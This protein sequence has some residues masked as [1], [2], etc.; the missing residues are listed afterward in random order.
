MIPFR[1]DVSSE[2]VGLHVSHQN[3]WVHKPT[4]LNAMA[5]FNLYELGSKMLVSRAFC[6]YAKPALL[7]EVLTCIEDPAQAHLRLDTPQLQVKGAKDCWR[8]QQRSAKGD[9]VLLT[10]LHILPGLH[11]DGPGVLHALAIALEDTVWHVRRATLQTIL[12]MRDMGRN[13]DALIPNVMAKLSDDDFSVRQTAAFALPSLAKQHSSVLAAA[14]MRALDDSNWRV[15]QA[16][17]EA[18]TLNEVVMRGDK[19]LVS[20]VLAAVNDEEMYVCRAALLALPHV[21]AKDD[22]EVFRAI[23]SLLRPAPNSEYPYAGSVRMQPYAGQGKKQIVLLGVLP[24]LISKCDEDMLAAVMSL[25]QAVISDVRVAAL[26]CLA[27]MFRDSEQ[28]QEAPF[29]DVKVAIQKTLCS[30]REWPVRKAAGDALKSIDKA[31]AHGTSK[32]VGCWR[33][34]TVLNRPSG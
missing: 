15:R 27:Q 8:D 22:P 7:Q 29:H 14:I 12:R 9:R 33:V 26:N 19:Q 30:D 34:L 24:N 28:R 1:F 13:M 5:C 10:A 17:L 21:A 2:N 18:L 11:H 32:S 16:V 3:V 23:Q 31:D 4:L 25:M 20:A 6:T